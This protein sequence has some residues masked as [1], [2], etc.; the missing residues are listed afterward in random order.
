MI[1]V[2]QV[3]P[4]AHKALPE[5]TAGWPFEAVRSFESA[6]TTEARLDLTTSLQRM[7]SS[8]D[9]WKYLT[10]YPANYL[11]VSPY[12]A[13]DHLLDIR[14]VGKQEQLMAKALMVLAPVRADWGTASYSEAFNWSTVIEALKLL[15]RAE[16]LIWR[17]KF[18]YTIAFRSVLGPT[19][20]YARLIGLDEKAH[21]EATKSGG[22]LK[23]WFG[24]PDINRKNLATCEQLKHN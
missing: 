14:T 6:E 19:A 11:L 21:A 23:Y 10:K 17:E 9:V 24:E 4:Q 7:P 8:E 20:D 18:F 16:N 5:V 12:I 22:L 2:I 13:H 1:E 15:V 3:L